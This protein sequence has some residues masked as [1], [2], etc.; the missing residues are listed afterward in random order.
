MSL[1]DPAT[2][3][4]SK[5]DSNAVTQLAVDLVSIPSP[6]GSERDIA[7]FLAEYMAAG[8]LEVTL[9]DVGPNRAN[10]V[11][12][13]RG[14]G[15]GP[16]LMFN[17]HLDTSI[18]GIEEEDYPMTGP[19]G[20]A[21][22]AK[23]F[24]QDGHVLGCGAYNMKGGVAAMVSAALAIKAAGVRLRGDVIVAAVAGEIEKAPVKGLLRTYAGEAYNGGG[25]GTRHLLSRGHV[26][27][28]ALVPEPTHMGV[29]RSRLGLL[30]IKLTTRGDMVRACFADKGRTA[31]A[32][33]FDIMTALERDFNPRIAR[34]T[35]VQEDSVY[36]PGFSIGAVEAGWPYKPWASPAVCCAYIDFRMPLG[37]TVLGAERELRGFLDE[38]QARD[39]ELHVEMEVFLS[40]ASNT[41]PA[42]SYIYS[43]CRQ[44]FEA[45]IGPYERCT[46]P[47]ASYSDDTCIM[48]EQAMEA[49]VFG[50]G[51]LR[52]R[53]QEDSRGLG[54]GGEAVSIADMLNVARVFTA[55]AVDTCSKTRDVLKLRDQWSE[56]PA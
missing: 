38:L 35:R 36:T 7:T 51:G 4:L 17:G 55:T 31:M 42:D 3:A 46:H 13:L 45:I 50:P 16:R 14:E 10:A 54:I 43:S 47:L 30:F 22:R 52:Y 1:S 28:Y 21:S 26:T 24:V 48:R 33:M 9:Q 5:I 12:I 56:V 18:T 37:H 23:G 32:K 29:L 27:D 44:H 20:P 2:K 53:G 19:H 8:G 41:T 11:G 40:K 6:T 39:P 25:V 49:V 34:F 15:D